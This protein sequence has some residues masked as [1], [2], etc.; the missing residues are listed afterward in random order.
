M[1]ALLL[2]QLA[3]TLVSLDLHLFALRLSSTAAAQLEILLTNTDNP[4]MMEA[5]AQFTYPF[6]HSDQHYDV[7]IGVR[8]N[9]NGFPDPSTVG[10][11]PGMV[12]IESSSF[13]EPFEDAAPKIDE[14]GD[15]KLGQ[16]NVPRKRG[17]PRKHPLPARDVQIKTVQRRS[18]TGCF[19]CKRRKKKCDETKPGYIPLSF[20]PTVRRLMGSRQ[21]SELSEE[22]RRM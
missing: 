6:T 14:L 21:V 3:K 10:V 18:K 13:N 2:R 12:P 19:T 17:R 8:S 16:P 15:E 5:T 11:P 20:R 7:N 1:S 9:F 4:L 22:C